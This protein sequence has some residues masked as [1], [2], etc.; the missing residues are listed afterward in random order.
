MQGEDFEGWQA[1]SKLTYPEL[2]LVFFP[3]IGR[4]THAI[5]TISLYRQRTCSQA[6]FH[7]ENLAAGSSQ[8]R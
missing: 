1:E 3:S 8:I 4:Q 6:N 2:F 5:N 7:H